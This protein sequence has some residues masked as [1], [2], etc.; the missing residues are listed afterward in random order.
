M[1]KKLLFAAILAVSIQPLFARTAARFTIPLPAKKSSLTLVSSF[2][3]VPAKII[4]LSGQVKKDKIVLDW[5][6]NEN[7]T[8]DMFE[9]EKSVDGRKFKMAALVFGTDKAATDNYQFYEKAVS[10]KMLYRI[11]L[12]NKNKETEYSQV[13]EI[14]P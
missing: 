14:N 8:A 2:F 12:I 11:K 4:I 13:I 1:T 9:I 7:E 5:V 6:V 10:K 3:T